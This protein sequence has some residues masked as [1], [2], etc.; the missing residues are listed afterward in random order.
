MGTENAGMTVAKVENDDADTFMNSLGSA[1]RGTLWQLILLLF[2][3]EGDTPRP[4]PD[5]W[6]S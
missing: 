5:I 3:H 1:M 6:I 4:G 2:V